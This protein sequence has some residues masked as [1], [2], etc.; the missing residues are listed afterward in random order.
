MNPQLYEYIHRSGVLRN[1]HVAMI[2]AWQRLWHVQIPVVPL[3]CL[4][5]PSPVAVSA[6]VGRE[7]TS[8]GMFA[9]PRFFFPFSL[10]QI[11]P[12]VH[13]IARNKRGESLTVQSESDSL[14]SEF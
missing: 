12:L 14:R 1:T 9:L 13:F 4:S 5:L 2:V 11:A 8:P 3:L 10:W 6:S 7:Q